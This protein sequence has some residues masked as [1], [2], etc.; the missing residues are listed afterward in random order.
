MYVAMFDE[1]DE[2]IAMY[3]LA[4]TQADC[5]VG[6]GQATLNVDGYD[7]PSDWYLMVGTEAQKML[8][9]TIGLTSVLPIDPENP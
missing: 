2:G 4:E 3:K 1:V 6:A 5:P 9:G 8:D 7:L